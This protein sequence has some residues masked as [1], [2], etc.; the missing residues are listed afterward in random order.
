MTRTLLPCVLAALLSCSGSASALPV[1]SKSSTPQAKRHERNRD[2]HCESDDRRR[3]RFD[4]SQRRDANR[5]RRP[6]YQRRGAPPRLPMYGEVTRDCRPVRHSAACSCS[7][8]RRKGHG[9]NDDRRV[10]LTSNRDTRRDSAAVRRTERHDSDLAWT[11]D[12]YRQRRTGNIVV[13]D[14]RLRVH[15]D[16]DCREPGTVLASSGTLYV[17]VRADGRLTIRS[18]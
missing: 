5:D 8:C 10:V 6:G 16:A 3:D 14:T 12:R 15:A 2:R 17:Q 11:N 9:R 13:G 7:P 1:G 4:R 18:R